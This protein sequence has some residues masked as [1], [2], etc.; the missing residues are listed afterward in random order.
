MIYHVCRNVYFIHMLGSW[1]PTHWDIW[2][3]CHRL[4]VEPVARITGNVL[5]IANPLAT[6][7]VD[8]TTLKVHNLRS[9]WLEVY[10]CTSLRFGFAYC[11]WLTC[12]FWR[13]S[14][15]FLGAGYMWDNWEELLHVWLEKLTI[16]HSWSE[17]VLFQSLWHQI[18]WNSPPSHHQQPPSPAQNFHLKLLPFPSHQRFFSL[19]NASEAG[20][21]RAHPRER[22]A[23]CHKRRWGEAR[24]AKSLG[25]GSCSKFHHCFMLK[26][27]HEALLQTFSIFV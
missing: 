24:G 16:R 13:C 18:C 26:C 17:H 5:R 6:A 3:G 19:R 20:G 4:V 9:H 22:A 12:I 25:R 21:G 2:N 11:W 14:F 7:S 23:E 1:L 10:F 15:Y 8:R 27:H